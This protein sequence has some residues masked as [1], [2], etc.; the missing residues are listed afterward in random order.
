M[1]RTMEAHKFD[2]TVQAKM[3]PGPADYKTHELTKAQCMEAVTM[4]ED[5]VLETE[6]RMHNIM[7][8]QTMRAEMIPYT[9]KVDMQLVSDK[10][11]LK[12]GFTDQDL[13]PNIKKLKLGSDPE[14]KAL[15][16]GYLEKSEEWL[17]AL[18]EA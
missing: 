8:K 2:P 1:N 16:A 6:R 10:M 5:K 3:G 14:F 15:L 12:W 11:F 13:M 18:P 9:I 7:L 4:V 17:K